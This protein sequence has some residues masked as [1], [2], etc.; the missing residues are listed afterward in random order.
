MEVILKNKMEYMVV[1]ISEFANITLKRMRC[2]A[3]L[4]PDSIIKAHCMFLII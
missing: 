2:C 4:A 1:C 3:T